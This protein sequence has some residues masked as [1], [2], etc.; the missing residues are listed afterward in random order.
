VTGTSAQ[1]HV[2]SCAHAAS[3]ALVSLCHGPCADPQALLTM[4]IS[5]STLALHAGIISWLVQLFKTDAAY[6]AVSF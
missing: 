2:Q 3:D 6:I 4:A 5:S 1:G